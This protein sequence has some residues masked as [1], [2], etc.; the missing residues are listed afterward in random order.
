MA[1]VRGGMS[2]VEAVWVFRVSHGSIRNWKARFD[3]GGAPSLDSGTPGRR[4]GEQTKLSASEAEALVGSIVDSPPMTSSRAGSCGP[5]VRS[6]SFLA[7]RL[8]GVSFTEQGM[9]KLLRCMGFNF[10]RLGKRAREADPETMRAWVEETYPALRERARSEGALV[11]FGDQ[12]RVRSD[13]LA[14]RTWGRKGDV[15]HLD[16]GRAPLHRHARAVQRRGLP[17]F[18]RPTAG[19]VRGEDAPG[20]RRARRPPGQEGRRVGRGALRPDRAPLPAG[21]RPAPHPDELVDAGLKRMLAD[22]VITDRAQTER[23]VRVF[24]HHVQKLPDRVLGYL[25]APHTNYAR[26][27]VKFRID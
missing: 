12:V 18:P 20:R 23:A 7:E 24:L 8:F 26:S 22:R 9:G 25:P 5:A 2:T 6:A 17:C 3:T 27:T 19:P 4:V 21:L 15:Y 1:A 13:Q 14:G 16:Q 11:L 10:Q